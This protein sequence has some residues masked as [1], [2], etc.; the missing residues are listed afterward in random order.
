MG[1]H[2][3]GR[4]G[5]MQRR[6]VG[7]A[8]GLFLC[9]GAF[10]TPLAAA[11]GPAAAAAASPGKESGKL[12][13]LA[14]S[15]QKVVRLALDK[16]RLTVDRENWR[17]GFA[18]MKPEQILDELTERLIKKGFPKQFAREH[19]TQMMNQPAIELA[20]QELQ[21]AAGANHTGTHSGQG[22][23]E[24]KFSGRGLSGTLAIR[25]KHIRME[26]S[27]E[28]AP[29][30][31][32]Q[33]EDDGKGALRVVLF[34]S[35]GTLMTILLQSQDGKLQLVDVR[36]GKTATH[37]AVDFVEFYRLQR[38]YVEGELFPLLQNVG[39]GTPISAFSTIV[40]ERVLARLNPLQKEEEAEAQ[41]LLD[42]LES[43]VFATR[44]E[45]AKKLSGQYERFREPILKKL[46][47]EGISAETLSRLKRLQAE[48]PERE[49]IDDLITRLGLLTDLAYLVDLLET[50]KP[51]E[52]TPILVALKRLSKQDHGADPAAWKTWLKSRPVAKK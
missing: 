28:Q 23:R 40:Q 3:G 44:E 13:D 36:G 9:G 45:A 32:L 4:I 34:K 21:Q 10:E 22:F 19:A 47:E 14:P 51:A 29:E 52:R 37:Q 26:F 46:A 33:V 49:T 11:Q 18:N 16:N 42:D 7:V 8:A 25:D 30:R 5:W 31:T 15:I 48:R 12:T 43:D 6:I 35:D 20:W 24:L 50:A 41:R 1:R 27:E 38:A 17:A 2:L 39:V